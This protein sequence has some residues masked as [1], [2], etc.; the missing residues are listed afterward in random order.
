MADDR[1]VKIPGINIPGELLM[2]LAVGAI[3]YQLVHK[4]RGVADG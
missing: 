4:Y 1:K 2:G 3:A